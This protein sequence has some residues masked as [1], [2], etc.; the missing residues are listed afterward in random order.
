MHG[1]ERWLR[2]RRSFAVFRTRAVGR[3]LRLEIVKKPTSLSGSPSDR[4]KNIR[5]VRH[6]RR[7]A[8][9]RSKDMMSSIREHATALE[10]GV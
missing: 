1:D 5:R 8:R 6:A 7:H 10:H 9:S 4:P 3:A 2:G